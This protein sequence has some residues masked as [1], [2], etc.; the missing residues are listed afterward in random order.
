MLR[1]RIR[2]QARI[3]IYPNTSLSCKKKI[4]S[5]GPKKYGSGTSNPKRHLKD[6]GQA[7]KKLTDPD[8]QRYG[9]KMLPIQLQAM[10]VEDPDPEFL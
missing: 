10:E 4:R 3:R 5:R 2:V 6:P 1:T 8:S 7:E 9:Q